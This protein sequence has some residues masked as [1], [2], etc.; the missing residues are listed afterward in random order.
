MER[1]QVLRFRT[2]NQL[3]DF[4][5]FALAGFCGW[6]LW[7]W[8]EFHDL[9]S[10][11]LGHFQPLSIAILFLVFY[12]ANFCSLA[13]FGAYHSSRLR[14]FGRMVGMYLKASLL[15]LFITVLIAFLE[16]FISTSRLVLTSSTIFAFVLLCCKEYVVRQALSRRR[17]TGKHFRSAII[18]GANSKLIGEIANE[19]EH[20]YLLG[21][22]II[23]TVRPPRRSTR[24][25]Q[26]GIA[27]VPVLG[28]LS[29]LVNIVDDKFVGT[30]IIFA[31]ELDSNDLKDVMWLCEER[32]LEMWLKL[33]VFDRLIYRAAIDSLR[34]IAFI[35]LRGGPDNELSLFI[36]A[37]FDRAVGSILLV[38]SSPLLL[39]ISILIRKT[40]P[41]P[42]LFTQLRGGLNGRHFTVYKFRSMVEDAD[43]R[44]EDLLEH[45]EMEGPVFKIAADPRITKL[46]K[47]L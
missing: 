4:F 30:V 21:L 2:V 33:N 39:I 31:D 5:V 41:G 25:R 47:F 19:C 13:Y 18:V 34:G 42:V 1:V 16:P 40:S 7:A 37:V 23:G 20:D 14:P 10:F 38:V 43:V 15:G 44:K 3:I 12:A 26:D 45:N 8:L 46:G 9:W 35:N 27:S 17:R 29:Q 11:P 6:A 24:L 32:G 22:K 36:K 28:P